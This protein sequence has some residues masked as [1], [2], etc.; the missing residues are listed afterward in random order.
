MRR[1]SGNLSARDCD[2]RLRH[3]VNSQNSSGANIATTS[4]ARQSVAAASFAGGWPIS[5][6]W[7][8]R[9]RKKIVLPAVPPLPP[10]HRITLPPADGEG[11]RCRGRRSIRKISSRSLSRGAFGA[12]RSDK[13]GQPPL[14]TPLM[15][16]LSILK[17]THNLSDEELCA[18]FLENPYDQLFCDGMDGPGAS[19]SWRCM[20]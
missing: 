15:A 14:P 10:P 2:L 20:G 8:S 11:N 6:I 1:R 7:S 17:H 4:P 16:G 3:R 19:A 12:V 13:P 18:R 5:T 9:A